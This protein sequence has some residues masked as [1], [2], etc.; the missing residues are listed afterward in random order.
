MIQANLEPE[1]YI[2]CTS[3]SFCITNLNHFLPSAKFPVIRVIAG[4]TATTPNQGAMAGPIEHEASS[5]AYGLT[6]DE[7]ESTRLNA[8]HALWKT[9][10]GYLLH[11][12]I[13]SDLAKNPS[14]GDI[15]TG[16]G[17]WIVDL[18]DEMAANGRAA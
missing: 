11:P 1:D 14:I 5:D 10:I 17:V 4:L 7:V 13:Q 15:G 6:R 16:T 18:A 12:R 3:S 8:Q 9:N 2:L